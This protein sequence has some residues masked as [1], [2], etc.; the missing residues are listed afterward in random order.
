MDRGRDAPGPVEPERPGDQEMS[1]SPPKGLIVALVTPLDEEGR[2]QR[3]S[4]REMIGRA[5][6]Y[7][8]VL[9]IG[10]GVIGEGLS[11]PNPVRLELLRNSAELVAG[12]KPL[13]LCPTAD[14]AE[15]TISNIIAL[16]KILENYPGQDSLFWVDIPLWYHSNRKLPQFYQQWKKYTPYPILLQNHPLLIANLNHSLKRTNIRTAVLK[17]LAENERIVGVIQ[18]GDLKRT[19]HYQ[20]AVRARRDFRFYDGD[21]RNFLNGPS[22]SGV[23]S[24]GA[25]L[26]PAEWSEVVTASL[27]I[28]EDPARN[29]LL[30]KQS[31]KLM[32]LSRLLQKGPAL[33]LKAAFHRLGWTP[34][35][36]LLDSTQENSSA[37]PEELAGFLQANFSLQTPP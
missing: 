33:S 32:D 28:S 3:E 35:I 29:L 8:D 12:K 17:R 37:D 11:L 18:A 23:V 15:E 7:S 36:K 14:T 19:I 25:N 30:L 20:R 10:E 21:E 24:A 9:M 1:P 13:F 4:L 5:L 27:R 31:Q 6:P 26:L 16:T 34:G 2:V 22:V